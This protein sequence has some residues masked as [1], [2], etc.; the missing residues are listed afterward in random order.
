MQTYTETRWR[1]P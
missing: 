1:K